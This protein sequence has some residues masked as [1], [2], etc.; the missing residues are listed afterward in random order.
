[1]GT[2][3]Y[4]LA[5]AVDK[6]PPR[7]KKTLTINDQ[8]VVVIVCDS[9]IYAVLDYHPEKEYGLKHGKVLNGVLV[10]PDSGAHYD[11]HTGQYLGGCA[12]AQ[13]HDALPVLNT[14]IADGNLYV[15]I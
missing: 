7:G 3:G 4:K 14:K 6:L 2:N 8:T 11:L 1:M 13:A 5:C 10:L 15:S 9:E 12:W